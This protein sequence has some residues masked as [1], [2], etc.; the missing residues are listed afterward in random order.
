MRPWLAWSIGVGL[1]AAAW[2]V[3]AVTPGEDIAE[4]PFPVAAPIGESASGRTITAAVTGARLTDRAVAEGWYADGTWLV[5]DVTAAAVREEGTLLRGIT[6]TLDGR[7]YRASER[8]A[9][10]FD[11]I[12]GASLVPGLPQEGSVA[13]EL[14]QDAGGAGMLRLSADT[15]TRLDSVIEVP[16]DLDAIDQVAETELIPLGWAS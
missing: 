1:L 2:V 8:P 6:F 7:T 16:I 4:A 10:Y 13:F 11:S 9:P 3:T 5:V 12:V 14:P 15:E